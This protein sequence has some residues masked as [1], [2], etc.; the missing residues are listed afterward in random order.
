[1]PHYEKLEV[2]PREFTG[3][4]G[5]K[6]LRKAGKV[7]AVYYFHGQENINLAIDRKALLKAL[8]S[9]HHIYEININGKQQFVMV[10]EL[11]FHP[12]TDEIIHADLLRVRRSEKITISVPIEFEGEAAGVKAGGVFMQNLTFLEVNCFPTDVPDNITVDVSELEINH[13]LTVADIPVPE[14]LEIITP[15]E[16]TLVSVQPPKVTV[17]A[18]EV[19]EA[20]V[21]AGLEEETAVDTSAA[22]RDSAEETSEKS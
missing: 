22:A 16:L 15:S 7:P 19:T 2:M 20:E 1:M 11:Q 5:A 18:E 10:K 12:V 9:G 17:E 6:A 4:K 8:H 13:S 3:S 21:E 14:G